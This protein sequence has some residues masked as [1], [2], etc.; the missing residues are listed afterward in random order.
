[1]DSKRT[2]NIRTVS[3]RLNSFHSAMYF[4]ETAGREYAKRGLEPGVE[5]NLAA[6]SAPLGRVNAGVVS[7]VYCNYSHSF[8]ASQIPKLWDTVSPEDMV[9]ARFEVVSAFMAELFGDR[10]DIALLT[11]AAT[12]LGT[13]MQPVLA[14]MDFSGRPLALAT[15]E[16]L[17]GHQ[18]MTA[19]EQLWDVATIAREYRGDG[20]VASLVTAGVPGIDALML[21]VATGASFR[22]RAAQKTRGFTDE[23]WKGAQTRLAEAG[24]ITVDADDRGF[25][26]PVITDAGRE[27]KEQVEQLTDG[28]VAAA[29]SVLSDEEIEA[30]VSPSRT[31]IKVLAQAGAFPSSVFAQPAKKAS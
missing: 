9:Q 21:D 18:P 29:W 3:A 20:H 14:N 23:E 8:I 6:R 16:A 26:L 17:V 12:E 5:G 19:F 28:T 22:P 4:S 30:M 7:A 25:D 15:A 31:L 11:E 24:L 13:G 1:M 2:Q 10:E 27:L